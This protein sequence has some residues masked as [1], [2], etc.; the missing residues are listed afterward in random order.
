MESL[1]K[2][3]E[4]TAYLVTAVPLLGFAT[5]TYILKKKEMTKKDLK[6]AKEKTNKSK[7][8]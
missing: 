3:V 2:S 8:G 6:A 1:I 7:A 5:G 4:P